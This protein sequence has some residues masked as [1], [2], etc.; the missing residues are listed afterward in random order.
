[1]SHL[2]AI[3]NSLLSI[4]ILFTNYEKENLSPKSNIYV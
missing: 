1:M 4:Q 3:Q 2:I